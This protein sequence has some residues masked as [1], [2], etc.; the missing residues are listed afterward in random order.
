[1]TI[2]ILSSHTTHTHNNAQWLS[3][4]SI[5]LK[6]ETLQFDDYTGNLQVTMN[7]LLTYQYYVT[8]SE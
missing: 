6:T 2:T 4:K 1:M 8:G 7:K 5:G 3:D